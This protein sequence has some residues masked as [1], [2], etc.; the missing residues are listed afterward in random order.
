MFCLSDQLNITEDGSILDDI[1]VDE[2]FEWLNNTNSNLSYEEVILPNENE[3]DT[4]ITEG[5]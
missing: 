1:E 3:A 5:A 2:Q 4:T